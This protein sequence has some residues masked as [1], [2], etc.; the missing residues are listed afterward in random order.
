MLAK[1]QSHVNRTSA[2]ECLFVPTEKLNV[3]LTPVAR[4]QS[5][6]RNL[7][8]NL[9]SNLVPR[10]INTV[11]LSP[12]CVLRRFCLRHSIYKTMHLETAVL[13]LHK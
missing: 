2:Q 1:F 5:D 4:S 7:S 11:T 12:K 13:K 6:I 3:D 9:Q 8:I 10:F